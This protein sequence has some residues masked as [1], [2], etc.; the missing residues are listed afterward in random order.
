MEQKLRGFAAMS[1]ERRRE[2]A[3][4]G[5]RAVHRKGSGYEWDHD[6][7]VVA[8]RKGGMVSSGGGRKRSIREPETK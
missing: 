4:M 5:G 2:I 3:S 7:A 8:G 6:S 1:P